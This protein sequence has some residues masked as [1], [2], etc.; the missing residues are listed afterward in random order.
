[1]GLSRED[2]VFV[3]GP[4]D[5]ILV[6]DLIATG[7][8]TEDLAQAWAWVNSDEALIGEGRPLPTGKVAELIDLLD[9]DVED[10]SGDAQ[11]R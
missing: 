9:A 7:A 5:E 8:S 10:E 2:V 11:T 6:A 1:M 4:V 3:L